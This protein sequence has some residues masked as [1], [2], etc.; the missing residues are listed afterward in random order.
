MWFYYS[1][2]EAYLYLWMHSFTRDPRDTLYLP[3]RY[4]I[5]IPTREIHYTL[6]ASHKGHARTEMRFQ[7]SRDWVDYN[8]IIPVRDSRSRLSVRAWY[9]A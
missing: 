6:P 1:L 2:M 8:D 4:T 9:S 5:P 3:E 7:G